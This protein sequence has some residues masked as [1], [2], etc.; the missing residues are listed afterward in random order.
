MRN[1]IFADHGYIFKSQKWKD[2]F[3]DKPWYTPRYEDVNDK[4][5]VIEKINIQTISE[6]SKNNSKAP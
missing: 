2:Y 3:A 5:S 4:L 6:L 1:E